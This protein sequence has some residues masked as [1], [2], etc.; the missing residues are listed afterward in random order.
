MTDNG[1][2]RSIAIVGGGPG[3]YVAAIRAAQLGAKVTLIEKGN[4]GGTCL[5]V[6]C[7][8]TK[9]LVVAAEVLETSRRAGEFGI[10]VKGVG[11]NFTRV[12]ERKQKVVNQLVSG[13]AGLLRANKV[14]VVKGEA[15]ISQPGLVTVKDE[16][17]PQEVRAD[18]VIL[19]TGSVPA[20]PPIPGLD[21]PGV[22]T[23]NEMV[24]LEK[25]P[26]NLVIIGGGYIGME[27]AAI[28]QPMGAKITIIEMLPGILPQTDDELARRYHQIARQQGLQINVK[29]TVKE[30][31]Q[32]ADKKL[33]VLYTSPEGDKSAVG[34]VVL[35]ATGRVPFTE[36]IDVEKLGL[37]MDRR[38]VAVDDYMQTNVPGVYAIGDVTGKIMLAHVAS[39]QGEVAVENI[40]GRRRRAD[41]RAVPGCIFTIPEIAS[42]GLTEQQAKEQGIEVK[43][44]KVPYAALGR[45]VTMGETAGLVKIVCDKATEAI[46]GVHI[47]GARATDIIAEAVLAIQMEALAEDLVLTIHAHP[48]LPEVIHEAAMGQFEGP[49]HYFRR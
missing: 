36:G 24:S 42:V 20:R 10:E 14:E 45:P 43:V 1:E 11:V 13:V 46:V 18:S 9:A 22:V 39:Y 15:S 38:A 44:S 8:P 27:M 32:T 25:V 16:G 48:T 31:R 23:S 41:Y 5:N 28:Y 17:A 37:K 26:E 7:I 33:E 3:G 35:V 12:M 4:L 2:R 40:L 49:I 47:M 21:L 30:I 34:D 6:G 29:S 19:A